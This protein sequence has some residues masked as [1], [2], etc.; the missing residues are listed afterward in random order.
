[1]SQV[2]FTNFDAVARSYDTNKDGNVNEL[3]MAEHIK[4]AVDGNKDGQVSTKE[5]ASS[6]RNDAVEVRNGEVFQSRGMNIHTEGLETLKNVN[7]IAR[8]GSEFVFPTSF[9]TL[10][11]GPDKDRAI[12]QSNMEYASAIRSMEG[13]LKNISGMTS[14]KGDSISRTANGIAHNALNDS[15]W[16]KLSSFVNTIASNNGSIYQDPFSNGNSSGNSGLISANNDL[17][18]AYRIL[19]NALDNIEST[20]NNLPDVKATAGAVDK[21]ISNAFSNINEIRVAASKTSPAEVKDK[22]YKLGAAQDAQVTGRA[23]PWAGAGAGIGA[24]VGG[25][26]GYIA[27]KNAKTAAMVAAGGAAVGAGIGALAG[28][29]KDDSF[30][31]KAAGLRQQA[32]EVANYNPNGDEDALVNHA[33]STYNELLNARNRSD[34]DGAIGTNSNLKSIQGNVSNIEGRTARVVDGYR[35]AG[36]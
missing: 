4:Q 11:D 25:V 7:N 2:G 14:G 30:K 35:K 21:S 26:G 8:Q 32:E 3:K 19:N 18:T 13:S 20:T 15:Q 34:I 31:E 6:L 29:S 9:E 23:A 33:G 1:M 22:L 36:Q 24:V 27:T 28:K 12:A 5:L 16:L 17:R 10:Q